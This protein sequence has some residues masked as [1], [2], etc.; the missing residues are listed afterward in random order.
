MIQYTTIE[1]II[2]NS[3]P[4][5]I[6]KG[7]QNVFRVGDYYFSVVGGGWGL[8]G[9]FDKTFEVA[10]LDRRHRVCTK[11]V[12]PERDDEVFPWQ[13]REQLLELMDTVNKMS[14]KGS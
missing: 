14:N 12:F 4:H 6:K 11:R 2:E 10:I 13:T 8:Y 7:R 3:K 5:A 1:E 9:D